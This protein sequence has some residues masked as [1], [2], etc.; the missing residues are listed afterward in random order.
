MYLLYSS[1]LRV[2]EL[3]TLQINHV[4]FDERTIR[5]RGKGE[6]DRIVLFDDDTKIMLEEFLQKKS[7]Q[8]LMILDSNNIPL[9]DLQNPSEDS[10]S[11]ETI[12]KFVTSTLWIK[13]LHYLQIEKVFTENQWKPP[14][15][16]KEESAITLHVPQD[17]TFQ[18]ENALDNLIENPKELVPELIEHV[19]V[20]TSLDVLNRV[21]V[22]LK[23]NRN[24][25]TQKKWFEILNIYK[26]QFSLLLLDESDPKVI[27][28]KVYNLMY[29]EH[30]VFLQEINTLE[31]VDYIDFTNPRV[32][33]CIYVWS[34]KAS[35][36]PRSDL[37]YEA[38]LQFKTK[39]L[40]TLSKNFD[41]F[42]ARYNLQKTDCKDFVHDYIYRYDT[43]INTWNKWS[44][45]RKVSR[46][47]QA[48]RVILKALWLATDTSS[49]ELLLPELIEPSFGAPSSPDWIDW[50]KQI[51][52]KRAKKTKT[53]PSTP[54]KTPSKDDGK[55]STTIPDIP[56]LD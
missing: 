45:C 7:E 35:T 46:G 40:V 44:K 25:K 54:K 3:V 18:T 24:D 15:S 41:A 4:D 26:K 30:I 33:L 52:G 20:P 29:T 9:A 17:L 21:I 16:P 55:P 6:K 56:D 53:K 50:E 5:I 10:L 37:Y 43:F 1:G 47:Y 38:F 34:K 28:D 39:W 12:A 8:I 14:V 42:A 49:E 31:P 32:V 19:D 36:K 11:K 27:F 22:S 2:S 51:T 13:V 23:K 48:M